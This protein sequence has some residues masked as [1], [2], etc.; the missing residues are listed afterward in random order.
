MKHLKFVEA[1][2]YTA[3]AI[4]DRNFIASLFNSNPQT[5]TSTTTTLPSPSPEQ[6][7]LDPEPATS[8]TERP[9]NLIDELPKPTSAQLE[10]RRNRNAVVFGAGTVFFALSLLITR[11]SFA[12]RRLATNPAFYTNAPSHHTQQAANVNGA[13]EAFEALTLATSNV[14]S[15]TMMTTGGAM[16]YLNINSMSDARRMLRGGLGVDGTGKSEKDA[17]EEFEEW[18]ATVLS[19]KDA[20]EKSSEGKDA[21]RRTDE[22]GRER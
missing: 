19:R 10:P 15:L 20:K 13:V 9:S 5:S 12:R 4:D 7:L 16:W 8:P 2:V 3:D 14:L 22:R 1:W 21:A 18:M 6:R 11:R 17:E